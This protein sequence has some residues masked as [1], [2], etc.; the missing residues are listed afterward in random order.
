MKKGFTK[1]FEELEQSVKNEIL[2]LVQLNFAIK[3]LFRENEE[4]IKKLKEIL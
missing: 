1:E 3:K 4:R 2:G